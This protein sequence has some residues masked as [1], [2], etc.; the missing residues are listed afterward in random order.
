LALNVE[1]PCYNHQNCLPEDKVA[2]F[3]C[4]RG[5]VKVGRQQALA[6]AG[7]Y[8]PHRIFHKSEGHLFQSDHP[9]YPSRNPLEDEL[10]MDQY[11]LE[12]HLDASE[13]ASSLNPC[14]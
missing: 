14:Y 7:K 9:Y 12:L 6:A 10:V 4:P 8:L 13:Q 1:V 5:F 11:D 2:H 3:A